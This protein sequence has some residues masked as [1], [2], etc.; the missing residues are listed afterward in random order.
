MPGWMVRVRG[1]WVGDGIRLEDALCTW[2]RASPWQCSRTLSTMNREDFPAGY[3]VVGAIIPDT[4]EIFSADQLAAPHLSLDSQAVGDRWLD[5]KASAVLR[6]PSAVVRSEFNYLLNPTHR[7]FSKI[8]TE[9]P[10]PFAFD[11]RLFRT[12]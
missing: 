6:V 4:L 7:E 3:V 8:V 2:P 5:S 12:K 10:V 1:A 11:E 9:L